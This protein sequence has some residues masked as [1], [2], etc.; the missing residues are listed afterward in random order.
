MGRGLF[1]I[2]GPS[3]IGP[4][5]SHTA[6]AVRIGRMCRSVARGD[7]AAATFFLHGSFA[8][9]YKGHGTDRALVGGL[10]GM[11]TDD[12]RI[13]NSLEL[14]KKEN[15]KIQFL[16]TNLGN[17]HPNTVRAEMVNKNGDTCNLI[18]SSIGGGEIQIISVNGFPANISGIYDALIIRHM[19]KVGMISKIA[20]L[21]EKNKLNIV[22]LY[23]NRESKGK[24]AITIIEIDGDVPEYL[25]DLVSKI[26]G[27]LSISVVNKI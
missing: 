11:N 26:D 2:L 13:I 5:S 9:T 14:A 12:E 27:I 20:A 21:F 19:D 18:A 3:M 22:S 8:Q 4:S 10:L 16:P 17:Y 15:M 6:G 7:I 1:G 24:I 23:N 25:A